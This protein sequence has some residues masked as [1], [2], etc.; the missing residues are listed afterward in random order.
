MVMIFVYF[1]T[2]LF[3]DNEIV[4]YGILSVKFI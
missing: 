4:L 1:I 2:V 3:Q